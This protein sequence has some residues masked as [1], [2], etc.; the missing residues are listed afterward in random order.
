[1]SRLMKLALVAVAVVFTAQP[2]AAQVALTGENE[3]SAD[4]T[5]GESA[6]SSGYQ[7][8]RGVAAGLHTRGEVLRAMRILEDF[9]DFA[10]ASHD[11]AEAAAA[12]LDAAWIAIAEVKRSDRQARH[13]YLAAL[14]YGAIGRYRALDRQRAALVEEA[15]RLV[16]E[17]LQLTESAALGEAQREAIL[18]RVKA[19]PV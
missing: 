6:L 2:A 1:M 14:R 16:K 19:F 13:P 3:A 17:A 12:Y 4:P 9:G 5:I 10:L 7:T 8:V 18:A 15:E 11:A